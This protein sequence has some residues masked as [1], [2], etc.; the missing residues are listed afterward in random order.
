MVVLEAQAVGVP[1]MASKVSGAPDLVD[2]I[3]TGLF[4]DPLDP[5]S[6]VE[7][8]ERLLNDRDFASKIAR[9]AHDDAVKRFHPTVNAKRHLEI[10]RE[11]IG[12]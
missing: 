3:T 8:V 1:V 6:F 2:G 4:C 7:G 12:R 11:V 9:H 5:R 10:Y